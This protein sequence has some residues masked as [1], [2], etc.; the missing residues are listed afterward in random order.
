M[1]FAKMITGNVE[2]KQTYTDSLSNF[3]LAFMMVNS[4]MDRWDYF[5]EGYGRWQVT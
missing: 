4:N 2:S 1:D 3:N 5:E